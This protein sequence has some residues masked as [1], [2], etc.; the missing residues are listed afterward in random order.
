MK[1][2]RFIWLDYFVEKLARKHDVSTDEVEEVFNN[3]PRIQFAE[4]G[5]VKGEDLT[6]RARSN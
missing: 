1:I 2:E 5:E 6:S 3:R 4:R